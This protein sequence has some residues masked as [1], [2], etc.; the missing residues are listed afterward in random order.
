[1]LHEIESLEKEITSR[2]ETNE[3][4][5]LIDGVRGVDRVSA[6]ATMSE[7][8]D[9]GQFDTEEKLVS[10][11]GYTP[12]KRSSGGKE[13][14][15]RINKKSNRY[16]YNAVSSTAWCLDGNAVSILTVFAGVKLSRNG[17]EY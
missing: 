8:G 11:C 3:T 7:I 9:I 10:Y 5:K 1:M 16:L 13:I 2:T 12:A 14:G 17:G 4:V 6:A 15:V